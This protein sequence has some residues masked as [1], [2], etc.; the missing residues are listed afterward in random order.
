MNRHGWDGDD[1]MD[2]G[3]FLIAMLGAGIALAWVV[4][5]ALWSVIA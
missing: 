2:C 4:A 1:D 5:G 3:V